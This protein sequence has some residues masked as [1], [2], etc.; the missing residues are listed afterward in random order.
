MCRTKERDR[1]NEHWKGFLCIQSFKMPQR[2]ISNKS[3][4]RNIKMSGQLFVVVLFVLC[5]IQ[6]ANSSTVTLSLPKRLDDPMTVIKLRRENRLTAVYVKRSDR[7]DERPRKRGDRIVR[8]KLKARSLE[9]AF[10]F[11]IT[12]AF[13]ADDGGET[14][15]L[16][17]SFDY[18]ETFEKE[19]KHWERCQ[20][21]FHFVRGNLDLVSQDTTTALYMP[22]PAERRSEL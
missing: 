1:V 14:T 6:D 20:H 2:K 8:C 5:S 17:C 12:A 10:H 19:F 16:V 22:D 3:F 9:F 18:C 11:E 21:L 4:T 7:V 15:R 13:I